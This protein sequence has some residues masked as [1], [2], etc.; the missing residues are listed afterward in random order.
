MLTLVRIETDKGPR[1]LCVRG[2]DAGAWSAL[3]DC[4]QEVHNVPENEGRYARYDRRF[5]RMMGT[6]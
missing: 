6:C 1:V 3:Q 2:L 4:A 5:K